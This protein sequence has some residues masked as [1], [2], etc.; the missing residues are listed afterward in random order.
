[1]I[2]FSQKVSN[3]RLLIVRKL[4]TLSFII[5]GALTSN[6]VKVLDTI[7]G[8]KYYKCFYYVHYNINYVK[9]L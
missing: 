2:K 9:Y 6:R 3:R 5:S 8:L 1:M 4:Q 7:Y